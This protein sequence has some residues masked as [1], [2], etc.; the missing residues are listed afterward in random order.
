MLF[1]F[2]PKIW[3][4]NF[5]LFSVNL[6]NFDHFGKIC[7]NHKIEKKNYDYKKGTN[8]AKNI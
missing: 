6:T 4:G 2:Q 3:D 1:L 8:S 7:Q 5:H